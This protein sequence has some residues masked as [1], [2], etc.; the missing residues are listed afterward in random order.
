MPACIADLQIGCDGPET[1]RGGAIV[2]EYQHQFATV[3]LRSLAVVVQAR[4]R[5]IAA[6]RVHNEIRHLVSAC[7]NLALD[8][9]L[10][11]SGRG[12]S[13]KCVDP[14]PRFHRKAIAARSKN[15]TWVVHKKGAIGCQTY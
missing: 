11:V 14:N 5:H 8:K 12:A 10:T 7:E 4:A 9:H 1:S 15:A 6:L 2:A 3:E 13:G